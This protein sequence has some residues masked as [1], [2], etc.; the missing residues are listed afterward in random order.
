MCTLLEMGFR[1]LYMKGL[2]TVM[3]AKRA[4]TV[5]VFRAADAYHSIFF[6]NTNGFGVQL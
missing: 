3:E 4:Y 2:G 6:L 1:V 5:V